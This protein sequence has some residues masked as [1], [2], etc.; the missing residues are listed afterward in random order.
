[1]AFGF[2]MADHGLDSRP[3]PEFAFDGAEDAAFLTRYEDA[4]RFCGAVA[5]IPLIG[6]DAFDLAAREPFGLFDDCP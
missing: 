1:M 4:A 5:A 6:I 2:H 3:A